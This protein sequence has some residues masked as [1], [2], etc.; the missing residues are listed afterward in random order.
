MSRWGWRTIALVA[1]LWQ[2]PLQAS[3]ITISGDN[4]SQ[5]IVVTIGNATV[6]AVLMELRTKYGFEIDGLQNAN[7]GDPISATMNGNLRSILERL[8]RNWNYMIVRSE[9]A[10]DRVEKVLIIDSAYGSL[11]SK[12][13]QTRT[14][15]TPSSAAMQAHSGQE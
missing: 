5:D 3:T 8:L 13:G 6:D 11:P 9:T 7:K 1:L 15:R 12:A 14:A 10:E 2:T 4:Q